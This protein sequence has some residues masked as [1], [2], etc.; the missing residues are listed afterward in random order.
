[1]RCPDT[2]LTVSLLD[3]LRKAGF[4]INT[5]LTKL[6][7]HIWPIVRKRVYSLRI[8]RYLKSQRPDTFPIRAASPTRW[9]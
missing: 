7:P 4:K 2:Y 6:Y 8:G 5:E 3:G 9:W 1:M